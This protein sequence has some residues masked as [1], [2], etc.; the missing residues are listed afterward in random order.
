MR[1]GNGRN[2]SGFTLVELLVVIGIIAMLIAMLM[3]ALHRVRQSTLSVTCKARMH[4]IGNLLH[5][6]SLNNRGWLYPVGEFAE[7]GTTLENGQK[8]DPPGFY[9]TLGHEP[10]VKNDQGVVD[11]GQSKRWPVFVEGLGIWNH[12]M[13][14]CPSDQDPVEE[15]TYILNKHLADKKDKLVKNH[16]QISGRSTSDILMMGE[17]RLDKHDY[18]MGRKDKAS[19]SET[20]TTGTTTIDK[21]SEFDIVEAYKHGLKL[22]SNYLFLDYHVDLIPPAQMLATLDPW[23]VNMNVDPTTQTD[24]TTT[25]GLPQ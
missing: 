21:N 10:G 11:D 7:P 3:P 2:R 25:A 1:N 14:T 9:K 18:Y 8:V 13:L 12:P 20:T 16:T 17:K 6:Y 22:G 19:T 23:D 5:I 24:P 15:H 4:D